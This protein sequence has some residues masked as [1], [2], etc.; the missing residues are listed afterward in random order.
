MAEP[1]AGRP[2]LFPETLGEARSGSL[3]HQF[4]VTPLDGTVPVAEMDHALAVADDLYL[5]VPA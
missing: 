4:L 2:D 1:H 3:F 5:N